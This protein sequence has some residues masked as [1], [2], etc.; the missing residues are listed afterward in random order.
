MRKIRLMRKPAEEMS[1]STD[2]RILE[3]LRDVADDPELP[4]LKSPDKI[5]STVGG[6]TDY[7]G[8]RC[9]LLTDLGLLEKPIRG[10]YQISTLGRQFLNED[11]DA[12]ELEAD[13][14]SE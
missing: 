5:Q 1:T 8:H 3:H 7:I 13:D 6:S 4:N 11:L 2:E 9:R 14:G 10:G 12:S